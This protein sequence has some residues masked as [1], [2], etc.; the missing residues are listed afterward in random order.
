MDINE[1]KDG[2]KKTKLG[3]IPSDWKIEKLGA[4]SEVRRGASPRPIGNP[5]YFSDEGRGWVRIGDITS[6]K[7]YLNKTKQKLSQIG[8][9]NSVKVDPGDFILSICGT[10][11]VPRIVDIHA[12]IHDGFVLI[13]N[14]KKAIDK[15]FLF[16]FIETQTKK[17]A[18]GGQPGTQKNLNTNIIKSVLMPLP[19]LPEQKKIAGILSTWDHAI[20]KT[21]NLIEA[22]TKLKKG[23]MQQLLTGKV[24]FKEFVKK[25]GFK[26][27]KIGRIPEDWVILKI[28]DYITKSKDKIDPKKVNDDLRCV[29][30]EHI[31]QETGIFKG[32]TNIKQQSSIKNVFN[33]S[34]LLFGKLRPYLKKYWY[35]TFNGACSSEIWVLQTQNN[36]YQKYLYYLVQTQRFIRIC[37]MTSGTKMPRSDWNLISLFEVIIPS[38]SEQKQ[39][40]FTLSNLDKEIEKHQNQN[41]IL[42]EQKKGLMQ[43][44]LTGKTRVRI[45]E[46]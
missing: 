35:A 14:Y 4:I 21:E 34:D 37:N 26:D 41:K 1:C 28:K 39:I 32:L 29:E 16:Y 11:G 46:T 19:P 8:I 3:W 9:E 40:A 18:H 13:S 33:K 31:N 6:S 42:K 23:L 27:T 5:N 30:L 17:L 2:N 15:I 12:C 22:K 20:E 43:Q 7:M 10:I 45:E 24:R 44:L 38:I 25:E 36:Y